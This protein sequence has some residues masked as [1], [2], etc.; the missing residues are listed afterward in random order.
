[1][2]TEQMNIWVDERRQAEADAYWHMLIL[3]R[4]VHMT[5][6]DID[7]LPFAVVG[8]KSLRRSTD[9][10]RLAETTFAEYAKS[11]ESAERTEE[12]RWEKLKQSILERPRK[13]V[14]IGRNGKLTGETTVA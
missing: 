10:G 13:T 7:G 8:V 4:Y 1:M 9:F 14:A 2:T 6:E 11:I 12:D 5:T 3:G